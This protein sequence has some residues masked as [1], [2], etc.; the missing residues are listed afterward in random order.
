MRL[1][2]DLFSNSVSESEVS[3]FTAVWFHKPSQLHQSI[4]SMPLI[5]YL[6]AAQ[7]IMIFGIGLPFMFGIMYA[8]GDLTYAA[9]PP[10]IMTVIAMIRPPVMSYEARILAALKFA[11]GGGVKEKKK[12]KSKSLAMPSEGERAAP[13][14]YT[15]EEPVQQ[16]VTIVVTDKP[17]EI[18]LSLRRGDGGV[19]AGKKVRM[20]LDGLEIKTTISSGTGQVLVLLDPGECRGERI[21]AVHALRDDDTIEPESILEKKITFVRDTGMEA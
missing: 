7:A 11:F 16:D 20:L 12:A 9:A 8:T 17:Y 5:G 21:I 10:L 15:E 13:E 2:W 18:S 3:K 19:Y 14:E 4:F 6:S 1:L